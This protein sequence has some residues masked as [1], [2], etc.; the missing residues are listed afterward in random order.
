M[1]RVMPR[2]SAHPTRWLALCALLTLAAP[3]NAFTHVV[4]PGETLAAI[5]EQ[6]YGRIQF[7]R[8]LVASNGL[9]A[10]GG[11]PI[12][13]GMRLE[14]PALEHYRVK[15]GESWDQLAERFLGAAHRSVVLAGANGSSPWLPTEQ[16]AEIVIPYNLTLIASEDVS[17]VNVALRYLGN[18][19]KAW[20]L[21]QYNRRQEPQ[22]QRGEVLLVPLTELPLTSEGRDAARRAA[23]HLSEQAEGATRAKQQQVRVELP[24][25]LADVRNGRYVDAVRRGNHFL[26]NS[27]LTVEQY[28]AVHRQLLEAY[29]AL[30]SVGL[31]TGACT[32]WRKAD[33]EAVLD[34]VRMSPKL[35]AACQRATPAHPTP[36]ASP[37]AAAAG[38]GSTEARSTDQESP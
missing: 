16:G 22:V 25:L 14:V 12:L 6:F 9:D 11:S 15:S 8:L 19:E 10:Q 31:A 7:E 18:T 36:T 20:M 32:A 1:R 34:P 23:A 29:A 3:A 17:I 35:M 37:G 33:P 4:R 26:A 38:A 27:D 5:A 13:P 28:A 30:G 24:A 21:L 2:R